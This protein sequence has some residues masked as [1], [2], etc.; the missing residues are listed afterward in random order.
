MNIVVLD[1]Y[2]LNPGDLSWD[3]LG[4]LGHLKIYDRTPYSTDEII[5]NIGSAEIIFTNKTPITTEVIEACPKLQY[6]GVLATGFNVVDIESA[7]KNN[8]VVTN[9]PD[10]SSQT[11]AQFTMALLLEMCHHIGNHNQ[12]VQNN[13]WITSKDFCF[14]NHP[15]IELSGKTMGLIGFGKIGKAT[16]KLAQAFGMRVLVHNR[17]IYKDFEND[18]LQFVNLETLLKDADVISLHCPLTDNTKHIINSETI[19]RMKPTSLLINTSRGP[20]V[21]EQ[22]LASAL[23]A[24]RIAY[25]AVDVISEEPMK[26]SNPLLGIPNCIITP[27][28]AWATK[29]ART[30]LMQTAID[31]L[32]SFLN[33]RPINKV[34]H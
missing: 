15:L 30:R 8:I 21:N 14:W 23:E 11:V 33:G 12:A 3:Q 26:P 34:N 17:T 6:I 22:D 24:E 19:K 28:I 31:N 32:Q 20:L 13:D 4:K 2:T 9:V 16:A 27:H 5:D 7:S 1:G 25:A 18:N 29:E 10:Y